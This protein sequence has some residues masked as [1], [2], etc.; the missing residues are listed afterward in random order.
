[1][2]QCACSSH[3]FL[4]Y[5]TIIWFG[6]ANFLILILTFLW[7]GMKMLLF[8]SSIQYVQLSSMQFLTGLLVVTS[9]DFSISQLL[10]NIS[11]SSIF[12]IMVM[13][14]IFRSSLGSP[15][16]TPGDRASY[17]KH[18]QTFLHLGKKSDLISFDQHCIRV[19][20]ETQSPEQIN[21][22]S[23]MST[24]VPTSCMWF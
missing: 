22:T 1:M 9:S 12:V 8:N 3:S 17:S 10:M 14:C 18:T 4:N 5:T 13:F 21:Y 15:L 19:T 23:C 16:H 11:I 7:Q 20:C 24:V 2:Y 6:A